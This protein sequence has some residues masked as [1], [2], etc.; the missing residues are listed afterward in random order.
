[1]SRR[2]LIWLCA[3]MALGLFGCAS[4]PKEP[5][6]VYD[7]DG[8]LQE[9]TTYDIRGN[10]ASRWKSLN[11]SVSIFEVVESGLSHID[12]IKTEAFRAYGLVEPERTMVNITRAALSGGAR[13]LAVASAGLQTAVSNA[14]PYAESI[15]NRFTAALSNAG[16]DGE[17][18]QLAGDLLSA[19]GNSVSDAVNSLPTEIDSLA[20]LAIGAGYVRGLSVGFQE[21]A[22]FIKV[23]P[24]S[25]S[26]I[27]NADYNKLYQE[28]AEQIDKTGAF[29]LQNVHSDSL[30]HLAY[31]GREKI[32]QVSEYAQKEFE[33]ALQQFEDLL[34]SNF[35]ELGI[36]SR[37]RDK[38]I[39]AFV[40]GWITWQLAV[41]ELTYGIVKKVIS[42]TNSAKNAKV[43]NRSGRIKE[44]ERKAPAEERNFLQPRE[45]RGGHWNES[46]TV[47]KSDIPE[48]NAITGGKGVHFI[49]KAPNR[50]PDFSPWS[51]GSYKIA[52]LSGKNEE[53]FP[54]LYAKIAARKNISVSQAERWVKQNGLTPHHLSCNELMLVPTA[55]HENVAHTGAASMLRNGR[56]Q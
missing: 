14:T 11:D 52:G 41:S 5:L 47:W 6:S 54:K 16:L 45:G 12:T 51:R 43:A 28:F 1:M 48:V 22:D 55:L 39:G 34:D 24:G 35:N 38:Y 31:W 27:A 29:V 53:D 7:E 36:D 44:L 4:S 17:S 50:T 9:R 46:K 42:G 15:K 30:V 25:V 40:S 23:I 10:V 8:F 26:G 20:I 18:S 19:M 3:V 56:C 13:G 2:L 49:G 37:Y 33:S 21:T 32:S